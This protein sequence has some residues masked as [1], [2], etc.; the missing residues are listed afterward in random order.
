MISTKPEINIH[1]VELGQA[2]Y[3]SNKLNIT[4]DRFLDFI[5]LYSDPKQKM[6]AIYHCRSVLRNKQSESKTFFVYEI[7]TCCITKIK[8]M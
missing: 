4:V 6:P 1:F 3:I 8:Y 2:Y 5:C 7:Y